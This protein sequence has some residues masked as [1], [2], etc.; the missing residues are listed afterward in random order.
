MQ[1]RV[2]AKLNQYIDEETNLFLN[3][4]AQTTYLDTKVKLIRFFLYRRELNTPQAE[5]ARHPVITAVDQQ[6]A[7]LNNLM[8][9]DYLEISSSGRIAS[10]PITEPSNHMTDLITL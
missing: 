6:V 10:K 7:A 4:L 8:P 1:Q 5:R 3:T 2:V 9:F